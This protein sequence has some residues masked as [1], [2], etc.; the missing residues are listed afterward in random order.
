MRNRAKNVH[1]VKSF[2]SRFLRAHLT[3]FHDENYT[4]KGLLIVQLF[5]PRKL[6]RYCNL[7][8]DSDV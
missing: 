3:I 6:M 4:F 5:F 2:S 1:K 8:I 7:M